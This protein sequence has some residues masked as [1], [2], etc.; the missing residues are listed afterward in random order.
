M[1]EIHPI[2][3]G[4]SVPRSDNQKLKILYILDYLKEKSHRDHPVGATELMN[5][6]EHQH[7]ILC[8]R[9]TVYSDLSALQDYGVDIVSVPGKR[10]ATSLPPETF[11]CRN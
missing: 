10:A 3:E 11:N 6:L 8:N 9:K 4:C 5:M 2:Q 7:N 1:R